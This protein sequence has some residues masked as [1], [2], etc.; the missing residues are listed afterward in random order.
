MNSVTRNIMLM[1]AYDG[2]AYRGWQ[3]QPGGITVQECVES[4]LE[5]LTGIR[6]RILCAGRTDA[7][8]HAL[9]Q[10]ASFHTASTIPPEQYR[11]GLQ[12]FLPRDITVVDSREV[13]PDFHATFSAV[14]KRYRYLIWD[15]AV[16]PPFLR[17]FVYRS[18]GPLRIDRIQEALP[19][20]RGTH[21]FRCFES[22]FPNRATSVRTIFEATIERRAVPDLWTTTFSWHPKDR[23]LHENPSQPL[24]CFEI[25]AD[26]FLYNMVRTIVG[27]LLRIA[28]QQ[29]RPEYLQRVIRG[30][31]RSLAGSTAP[32]SGLCLLGVDYPEALLGTSAATRQL[33][34]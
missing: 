25:E 3:V 6:R 27:T 17:N 10:V 29:Q 16:T 2:T 4:A 30:K 34:D 19:A 8:V 9:G 22:N 14:R 28:N 11:R 26:G 13:A 18:R 31:D 5:R 15:A 1:L 12:R 21:D 33:A 20:L 7:G 32:A 24:I 23:R